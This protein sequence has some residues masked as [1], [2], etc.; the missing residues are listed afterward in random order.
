MTKDE[1]I[2]KL[3][4]IEHERRSLLQSQ[5]LRHGFRAGNGNLVISAGAVTQLGRWINTPYAGLP[6]EEKERERACARRYWEMIA[7]HLNGLADD[8]D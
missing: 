6:E 4:A 7:P 5:F 3:A 8:R 2:E 1:L